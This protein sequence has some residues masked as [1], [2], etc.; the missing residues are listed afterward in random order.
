MATLVDNLGR[1]G[2]PTVLGRA[3][4]EFGARGAREGEPNDEAW[5]SE[6]RRGVL[7][8]MGDVLSSVG[9]ARG[10]AGDGIMGQSANPRARFVADEVGREPRARLEQGRSRA[11]SWCVVG[12]RW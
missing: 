8:G 6:S 3:G 12:G 4:C 7:G 11:G 5:S 9:D 2:M 1:G 10:Y